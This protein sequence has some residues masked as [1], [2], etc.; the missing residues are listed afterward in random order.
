MH[1]RSNQPFEQDGYQVV[2]NGEIYNFLEIKKKLKNKFKF[3]TQSDT[4]VLLKSYIF[5]GDKCVEHF[6]GMWAFAIWD[7]NKKKLFLSR[8]PFGEKP[9]Y[10][11]LLKNSFLFGSE[12]KFIKSLSKTNFDFNNNLI[13][14]NLFLGYKSIHKDNQTFFENIFSVKNGENIFVDINL[15]IKKEI[16]WKPKLSID[17]KMKYPDAVSN[18]L[19][20]ICKSLKLR[21]RADV[22]I[23]F[24]LS[25]G[26]DSSLL[27]SLAKK[28]LNLDINTFSIYDNDE[29]YNELENIK[30]INSNLKSN[31]TI[32]DI[33]KLKSNFLKK[34]E[35]ITLYHDSPLAT[36]SYYVHALLTEKISKNFKV[37]ISGLGA[38]E[39]FTGYYDHYLSHL[40][41]IKKLPCYNENLSSWKKYVLPLIR[42]KSFTN[43]LKYIENPNNRD[44]IYETVFGLNKFS[45]TKFNEKFNEKNFCKEILRNRMF[46]EINYETLPVMLKHDDLNSMYNSIENRSPFLDKDLYNFS[47]TIPAEHF[48]KEG[49]QKKILRDA[50]NNILDD[51]VRLT[52]QKKG[53]NASLNSCLNF[54]D[55]RVKNFL[56]DKKS[57]INEFV[58][59][60]KMRSEIEFSKLQSYM[61]KYIFSFISTKIFLGDRV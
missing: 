14:K 8:D 37:T 36:I 60:E 2:F 51:R 54:E 55:Q 31:S 5:Y 12:I 46:N 11:S 27:A 43:P 48:I 34:V 53:F 15:N 56:F 40:A 52:R 39:I 28:K 1:P 30:L 41:T 35:E 7:P 19:D 49:F 20:L 13:K 45:N 29:R 61:S 58:N 17:N 33:T 23:A 25:G 6:N 50:G 4:E 26:V 16:Y 10:F 38:D 57:P 22:P 24:C 59:V 47:L 21:L 42:N 18:T 32:I 9:L 44:G 3:T